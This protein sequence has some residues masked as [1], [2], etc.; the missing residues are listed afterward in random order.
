MLVHH[1][2]C[3]KQVLI[4]EGSKGGCLKVQKSSYPK[5]YRSWKQRS[6]SI[7]KFSFM[8]SHHIQF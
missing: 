2:Q 8:I 6:I 1:P 3:K 7:F 5:K 4:L